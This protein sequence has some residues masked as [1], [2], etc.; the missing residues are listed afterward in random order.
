M[1]TPTP[2]YYRKQ[3]PVSKEDIER[4]YVEV[5][6]YRIARL[7]E[8]NDPALFQAFKKVL[9]GGQRGGKDK[10]QDAVEARDALNRWLELEKISGQEGVT[11][12]RRCWIS[13]DKTL[14]RADPYGRI[15]AF[16]PPFGER[17]LPRWVMQDCHPSLMEDSTFRLISESEA[18]A[19]VEKAGGVW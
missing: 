4:G 13:T 10:Q 2:Q 5:D 7:W 16:F 9:C 12:E 17:G 6:P 14:Y 8:L 1:S 18:R 11:A 19:L 15:E 3:I